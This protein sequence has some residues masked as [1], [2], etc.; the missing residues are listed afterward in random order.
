MC[1]L[2]LKCSIYL[3]IKTKFP[4]TAGRCWVI[5]P[6]TSSRGRRPLP[7]AH[8]S[9]AHGGFLS[10]LLPTLLPRD[11]ALAFSL[12]GRLGSLSPP[13]PWLWSGLLSGPM[14]VT[15]PQGT[16]G[17]RP[18]AQL[19]D[20]CVTS[21]PG[22]PSPV[23]RDPPCGPGSALTLQLGQASWLTLGGWGLT[24]AE[25]SGATKAA[26]PAQLALSRTRHAL[27]SCQRSIL[28]VAFSEGNYTLHLPL[29][30][31]DC[32]Q[33]WLKAILAKWNF[34]SLIG[35]IL[36]SSQIPVPRQK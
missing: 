21:W 26:C 23:R 34:Y 35:L 13:W 9:P 20:G 19:R 24:S 29:V 18:S 4:N 6:H 14:L 31:S 8:C 16:W 30:H 36:F 2:C 22:L 1:P 3:G 28:A 15:L 7:L 11:F 27:T 25:A 10:T 17:K 32:Q 5:N 12:P 33:A